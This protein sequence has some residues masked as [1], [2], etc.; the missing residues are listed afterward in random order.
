MTSRTGED[1]GHRVPD[2]FGC[3]FERGGAEPNP[4]IRENREE[5][6]FLEKINAHI[7]FRVK[8]LEKNRPEI[9]RT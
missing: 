7:P 9:R 2:I 1:G 6:V 5:G 3:F 8:Q 4:D